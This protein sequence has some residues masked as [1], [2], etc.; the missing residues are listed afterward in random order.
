MKKK[1]IPVI[2]AGG[3]G[4]RLWPLSRKSYP[5]QFSK[6]IGNTSL[7]EQSAQRLTASEQVNFASPFTLT[8]AEFRFIVAEQLQKAGFEPGTIIIEP[9]AKNTAAAI[10]AASL[11]I[12]KDTPEA[13]LLV[14]PSDHLIPDSKAFHRAIAAGLPELA[15]GNIVT[16]GITPTRPETG[17]GYLE[18]S[19]PATEAPANLKR[20]V[21]KP[22]LETARQMLAEG[23]YL[24]NAGIFMFR[25][26]D[27]I[28]AFEKYSSSL[29]SPVRKAVAEGESDLGFFRLDEASWAACENISIDYAIM[30]KADNLKVVPFS[31]GWSDLGDW[32]AVWQA[33]TP[34][35]EGVVVSANATAID[36]QNVLLRSESEGLQ[37]VGMGLENIIAVAMADAVLVAH[38]DHSQKVRQAAELLKKKNRP[39]AEAFPKIHRPW[40]WIETLASQSQCQLRRLLV[41]PDAELSMQ[42]HSHR[43]EHWIIIEGG[44]EVTIDGAIKQLGPGQSIEIPAGA[45]HKLAN[46]GK[47]PALLIEVQTGVYLGEDDIIRFDRKDS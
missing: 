30:E 47:T 43:S 45:V 28:S 37:L 7:F 15:D 46:P 41:K 32:E 12:Q 17:Y 2:L 4:T 10:L 40:G 8:N 35:Q 22:D 6:L 39:Q 5:K 13:V 29:L 24:W 1:V 19:H 33:E 21:E 18:L 44:V 11:Y 9:S 34:D 16:F 27:M 26:K 42:R 23:S 38:R 3:S 14:A 36:C 31:A 20:F 25:A